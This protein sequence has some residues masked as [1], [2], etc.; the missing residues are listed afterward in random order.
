MIKKIIIIFTFIFP[1]FLLATPTKPV[2]ITL[3]ALSSSSVEVVWE[4]SDELNTGYKILRDGK[5][6]KRIIN[7]NEKNFTDTGLSPN[8]N[9]T[10]EVKAT[11]DPLPSKKGIGISYKIEDWSNRISLVAPY[12]FYHWGKDLREGIP[13]NVEFVPMFWGKK[14]VTDDEIERLIQ[15]KNEGKIHYVLGFNEPDGK[16]Q[17]SMTVDEAIALWPKLEKIGLPLGSPATKNPLNDWMKE[18]MQKVEEKDL[19]VDFIAVHHYG[20]NKLSKLVDKLEKTH[21]DYGR[22]IWITEF[23]VADRKATS[24]ETNKFSEEDVLLFM[25]KTLKTLD[26]ID[27][28]HRYAWFNGT[29]PALATS[30]LFDENSDLTELGWYYFEHSSSK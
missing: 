18:F 11:D 3:T 10:Y 22:P 7:S 17:S 2:S 24:A 26:N 13:E 21:E 29:K 14:G 5:L 23:A 6:V 19:R 30:A 8:T 1:I 4:T 12:W 27:W 16:A 25:K 15:L 20:G 28:I 9:Y